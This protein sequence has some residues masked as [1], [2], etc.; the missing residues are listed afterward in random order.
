MTDFNSCKRTKN[1][2][3]AYSFGQEL[4]DGLFPLVEV[5]EVDAF[6]LSTYTFSKN[7]GPDQ[8]GIHGEADRAE[9]GTIS[10]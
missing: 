4:L 5:F 7:G 6:Q 3:S 8:R 9:C 2:G 10:G 1:L